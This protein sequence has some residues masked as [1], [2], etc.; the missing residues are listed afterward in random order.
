[1]ETYQTL[2]G[3]YGYSYGIY[4]NGSAELQS[5]GRRMR[6]KR[7]VVRWSTDSTGVA[8]TVIR[9]LSMAEGRKLLRECRQARI[10]ELRCNYPA[11]SVRDV[12]CG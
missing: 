3:V 10:D 4:D 6:I 8:C 2:T 1:M 7:D 11:A 12:L 5:N 9:Y